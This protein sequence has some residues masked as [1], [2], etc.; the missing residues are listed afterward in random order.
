MKIYTRTGDEGT[1]ALFG[2]GRVSKTDP[3]IAAYGTVDE[4]NSFIGLARS[5]AAD[6]PEAQRL[7]AFLAAIQDDLFVLGADLATP[8]DARAR[9]QRIS[10]EHVVRVERAI[11][12]LESDLP[13]LK[14]FILPG[15]TPAASA[16][17]VARAVCRRA[18]RLLLSAAEHV[19]LSARA[20]VY[21]NRLSDYLFVLGRWTNRKAGEAEHTWSP[22]DASK[23]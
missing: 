7:D 2:G 21:L 9:T 5:F 12:E 14:Q 10:E 18:E 4:M 22:N 20:A 6:H 16:L 17:H 8:S 23:T 11:D 3:R 1:T 19:D 13:E 15:G